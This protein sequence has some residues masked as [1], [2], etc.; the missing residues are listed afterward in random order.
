M[1]EYEITR[2][3]GFGAQA[4]VFA[5]K[6]LD[7]N[8][9]TVAI[10]VISGAKLRHTNGSTNPE[11][12]K[13]MRRLS[14]VRNLDLRSLQMELAILSRVSHPNLVSMQESLDFTSIDLDGIALVME[15]VSGN[16]LMSDEEL[17]NVQQSDFY[18]RSFTEK[19][20]CHYIAQV[21]CGLEYLHVNKIVHGDIK[22]SNILLDAKS[23]IVK[24]SDF[25]VSTFEK[26]NQSDDVANSSSKDNR[27]FVMCHGGFGKG[28]PLVSMVVFLDL[29]QFLI[30]VTQFFSPESVNPNNSEY[31]CGQDGDIWATAISM[32]ILIYGTSPYS[33]NHSDILKDLRD[34]NSEFKFPAKNVFRGPSNRLCRILSGMLVKDP[35]KRTTQIP[36]IFELNWKYPI[37]NVREILKVHLGDNLASQVSEIDAVNAVTPV[38][39]GEQ[40][41]SLR[42]IL[43]SLGFQEFSFKSMCEETR[44]IS[45]V[46]VDNIRNSVGSASSAMQDTSAA[47]SQEIISAAIMIQRNY[48]EW[49]MKKDIKLIGTL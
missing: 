2:Q 41:E 47:L 49:G 6:D 21:L 12:S 28:T 24:I 46:S 42:N 9:L 35:K 3:L 31:Y 22:P 39:K 48:R 29:F 44:R 4:V 32:Y 36:E 17:K 40:L 27:V 19:Q 25:G 16:P 30:V 1:N 26:L 11:T 23:G 5:A 38:A 43:R 20:V 33:K 37:R 15:Y 10:R 8:G 14:L 7:Q 45:S 18:T 13:S 34:A